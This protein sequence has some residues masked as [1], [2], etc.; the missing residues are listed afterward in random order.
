MQHKIL[1]SLSFLG[2]FWGGSLGAMSNASIAVNNLTEMPLYLYCQLA[3]NT[4]FYAYPNQQ[5]H[6]WTIAAHDAD[7]ID[8][9]EVSEAPFIGPNILCYNQLNL[10]DQFS[11]RIEGDQEAVTVS[12]HFHYDSSYPGSLLFE[13]R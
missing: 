3:N 5:S 7:P 4:R 9:Y 13:S 10:G 1:W 6:A 2:I 8:I 12:G 11:Y